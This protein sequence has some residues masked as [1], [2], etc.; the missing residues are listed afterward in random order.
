M[1]NMKLNKSPGSDGLPV[2][3]YKAFWPN[4]KYLVV[5]SLN[6]GYDSGELSSLQ[7]NGLIR[8]IYKKGDKLSLN[9]SR[10]ISLLNTDFK[11]ATSALTHKLQKVLPNIINT[12]QAGYIKGIFI[13]HNI[14]LIYNYRYY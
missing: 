11:I 5:D 13:G 6:E 1:I 2:E 7:R 14:R 9:N 10:P 4:N 12:D 3:F 8:L